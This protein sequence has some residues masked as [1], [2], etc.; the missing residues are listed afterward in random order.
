M[1][2]KASTLVAQ[3]FDDNALAALF[4]V[5]QWRDP[6]LVRS[7]YIGTMFNREFHDFGVARA[8]IAGNR[9]FRQR[10]PAE[11]INVIDVDHRGE[12]QAHSFN[13]TVMTRR[14]QCDAAV[15]ISSFE[16]SAS[17][18]NSDASRVKQVWCM[19]TRI[20]VADGFYGPMLLI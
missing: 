10:G 11:I 9:H 3:H 14:Y 5:C 20:I 7:V 17:G 2:A 16:I 1:A 18:G 8:A 15:A 12:Q 13:M 4:G 19:N 6:P